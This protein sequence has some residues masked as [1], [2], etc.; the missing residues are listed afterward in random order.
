MPDTKDT[1]NSIATV[2]DKINDIISLG[3]HK[4]WKSFFISN[5]DFDGKILDIATGTGDIISSIKKIYPNTDCYGIDPSKNMLS[6]ARQKNIGINFIEAYSEELPFPENSFDFITISFGIRNTLSIDKSLK[7]IHR[8]LKKKQNLLVMEFSKN[9]NFFLKILT[10]L[11][12]FLIIPIVGL[13]YGKFKEY[14]YLSKSI[15]NFYTPNEFKKL[16]ETNFFLVDSV[17]SFNFG[18]VTIYKARKL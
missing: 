6:I 9:E 4:D 7:E 1:F 16:L 11:Y 18:L 2:Y 15:S 14:F 12:L 3:R 5:A 8:V 13:V 17:Q 10:N